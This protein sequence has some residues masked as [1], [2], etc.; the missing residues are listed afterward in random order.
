MNRAKEGDTVSV[1]YTGKLDDGT[2]FDSS[3]G[4]EPLSFVLGQGQII[5]G[6]E[7]GVTGMAVGESK[8]VEIPCDQAYGQHQPEKVAQVARSEFAGDMKLEVGSRLQVQ[9][10]QA[11][12]LIF[13][14]VDLDD[15]NVTLDANH[16]LAGK[17]LVFELELVGISEGDS[18]S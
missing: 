14:V 6:F 5:P 9:H 7:S 17:D 11:G 4:G 2:V 12:M 10:P 1:H 16:P 13:S 18:G 8:M 3:S 15:E